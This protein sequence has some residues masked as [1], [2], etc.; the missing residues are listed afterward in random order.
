MHCT[1]ADEKRYFTRKE[2][3]KWEKLQDKKTG[4]KQEQ[5]NWIT[6]NLWE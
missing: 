1:A 2:Q 5:K 3:E 4:I 6:G